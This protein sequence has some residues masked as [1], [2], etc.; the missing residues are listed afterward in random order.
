MKI[1][2]LDVYKNSNTR[3]SKDTAGGYGTENELGP[4]PIAFFA[5]KFLRQSLFWPSLSFI[6][7]ATEIKLKNLDLSYHSFSIKEYKN[8]KLGLKASDPHFFF[9]CGSIVCFETEL[10]TIKDLKEKYPLSHFV[11][12][13]SIGEHLENEIPNFIHIISG[14]YEFLVE[15]VEQFAGEFSIKNLLNYLQ[16]SKVTRVINGTPENLSAID[17]SICSNS[18]IQNKLLYAGQSYPVITTR[19]CPYSC[20]VY[21]TYPTSQGRK[22]LH[23]DV[24]SV[25]K[26]LWS[27]SRN[28]QNQHIIFRDPVFSINLKYSKELLQSIADE[29]LNLAFTAELHL[30]NLD[31]E[32]INLAKKANFKWFKFG[33]E[34]AHES[35][36]EASGRY[37]I[38]NDIQKQKIY[39]LNNVGIKADGMF[40]LC[41]PTDTIESCNSTIDYSL[42]LGLDMAQFSIFTPY[43]GTPYFKK[44]EDLINVKKYQE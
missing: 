19:G 37:S 3:I 2:F 24:P 10:I 29:K 9:I 20:Y 17:W 34:S 36:R 32:F 41:Q 23:E 13:G 8:I 7:L 44:M 33:I 16:I 40:I 14:N 35:I 21:C 39:N 27:I 11:Y 6:Q 31:E 5:E 22:V 28:S 30:K 25:I 4:G 12:C 1:L 26:K 15:N 38:N 43:P 42:T 18:K